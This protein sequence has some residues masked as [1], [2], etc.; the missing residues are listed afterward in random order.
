[1]HKILGDIS[2]END[3]AYVIG[4]NDKGTNVK[5]LKI[6]YPKC[7]RQINLLQPTAGEYLISNSTELLIKI[8]KPQQHFLKREI[9]I[10]QGD[11]V[12]LPKNYQRTH[13]KVLR[14]SL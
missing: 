7:S 13:V 1:M 2:G 8:Q 4:Q 11:S 3:D 10:Y 5:S 14:N 12:F 6:C 9:F